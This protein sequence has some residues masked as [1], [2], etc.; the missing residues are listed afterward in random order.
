MSKLS[1]RYH[2]VKLNERA[3]RYWFVDRDA[4]Q[5]RW[6]ALYVIGVVA[7]GLAAIV[8]HWMAL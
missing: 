5:S 6:D 7:L 2:G 8:A 1:S 3:T 4:L